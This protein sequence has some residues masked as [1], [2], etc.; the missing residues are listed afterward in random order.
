MIGAAPTL[1]YDGDCG[2]CGQWVEYW[3]R[4]TGDRVVYRPYQD[5]AS[6][7][8]AI[9]IDEFRRAIQWIEPDGTIHA[10]A[11]ATFRVLAHAPGKRGWWWLYRRVPGFAPISE[12]CYAFFARRRGL[13][14]TLTRCLWGLPLVPPTYD[15]VRWI[16]L[17]GIGLI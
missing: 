3:R 4:L 11:A 1:I 14:A 16:F 17:R 5:A 10:G 7:F 9:P 12:A 2:I 13:L 15:I 6:D 8:P